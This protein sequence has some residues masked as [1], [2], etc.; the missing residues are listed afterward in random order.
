MLPPDFMLVVKI[1][2]YMFAI[3][4]NVKRN[5]IKFIKIR[6]SAQVLLQIYRYICTYTGWS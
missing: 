5:L 1:V 4:R 3:G 6:Q 2:D